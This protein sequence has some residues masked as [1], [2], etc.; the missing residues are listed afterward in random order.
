MKY[1]L[2]NTLFQEKI[3]RLYVDYLTENT[4]LSSLQILQVNNFDELVIRFEGYV[5]SAGGAR[6]QAMI[7][8]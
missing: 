7:P 6:F 3:Q 5:E 8:Q 4:E 1:I 2:Q